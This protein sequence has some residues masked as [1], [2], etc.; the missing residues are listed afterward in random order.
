MSSNCCRSCGKTYKDE[1][2]A[3]IYDF[4]DEKLT[5]KDVIEKNMGVKLNLNNL[6]PQKICEVCRAQLSLIAV[7]ASSWKINENKLLATNNI[8]ETISQIALDVVKEE[9]MPT[10]GYVRKRGPIPKVKVKVKIN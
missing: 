2:K 4:V 3:S 5:F 8:H 9:N 1:L 7:L 10:K 6:L